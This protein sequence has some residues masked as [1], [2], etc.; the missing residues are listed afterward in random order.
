MENIKCSIYLRNA[1]VGPACYYRI[2]QYIKDVNVNHYT[3]NLM[4]QRMFALNL[5]HLN[6]SF[7]FAIKS[8]LYLLMLIRFSFFL[9]RDYFTRPQ[10]IIVQRTTLP[11]YIPRMLCKLLEKNL[12]AAIVYWD[13][14]DD[15]F[16]TGEISKVE[17]DLLERYSEAIIVTNNYLKKKI[18]KKYEHKVHLLP[19]TDGDFRNADIRNINDYRK[20]TFQEGVKLVWVGTSGNLEYLKNIGNQLDR[21]AEKL[22]NQYN[23]SLTLIVVCNKP[24]FGN[25]DYLIVENKK[26]SRETTRKEI[27]NAHIGIMPLS[28]SEFALGKGGFK[29]VQYMSAGLPVIASAIGFN[30]EVVDEKAGFLIEDRK[31]QDEWINSIIYMAST[32]D[33]WESFSK[34]AIARWNEKFSYEENLKLWQTM[35][36]VKNHQIERENNPNEKK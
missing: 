3:N 21:A 29:L 27:F 8:F 19:T 20:S 18:T 11:R 17:A 7:K 24:Y 15:I 33:V 22:K 12:K 35:L 16:I 31:S 32:F 30:T 14:D 26:W 6:S 10:F 4:S 34:G 23:K 9:I 5:N 25:F 1:I 28:Y 36:N 13:F 2:N